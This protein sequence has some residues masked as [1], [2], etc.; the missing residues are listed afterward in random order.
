MKIAG[1]QD[2]KEILAS[3]TVVAEVEVPGSLVGEGGVGVEVR[4]V[5]PDGKFAAFVVSLFPARSTSPSLTRERNIL[6]VLPF[7]LVR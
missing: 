7:L 6:S 1:T 4:W 5:R 3:G 2:G